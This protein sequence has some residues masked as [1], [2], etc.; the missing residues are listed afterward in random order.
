[1][2]IFSDSSIHLLWEKL[3]GAVD[4][5]IIL[6][7]AMIYFRKLVNHDNILPI[8]SELLQWEK[9]N[10]KES[11]EIVISPV[12]SFPFLN[13]FWF[14]ASWRSKQ[15]TR[16]SIQWIM[17]TVWISVGILAGNA[18]LIMVLLLASFYGFTQ[19]HFSKRL[20]IPVI[21]ECALICMRIIDWSKKKSI[22]QQESH[23][24]K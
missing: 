6:R 3:P 2:K 12:K 16:S 4:I 5:H 14:I 10:Y 21:S 7:T 15:I 24:S 23:I 9:S 18:G 1:V 20:D 17:L 22:M 11:Q 13:I 8:W 19:I